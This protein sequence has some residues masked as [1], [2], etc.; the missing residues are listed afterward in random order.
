MIRGC[1][2]EIGRLV[3]GVHPRM[4]SRSRT[5][6]FILPSQKLSKCTA[7][8]LR[9]VANDRSQK[10]DYYRIRSTIGGNRIDYP[11]NI[12]TLLQSSLRSSS[13]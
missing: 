11:G 6:P 1:S 4:I 12:V 3:C 13:A 2:N 5:I 7:T 8:Y 9:I 10:K